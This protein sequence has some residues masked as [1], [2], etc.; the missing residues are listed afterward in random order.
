MRKDPNALENLASLL[1]LGLAVSSA[2]MAAV[3]V[4]AGLW[5]Y[6]GIRHAAST[7]TQGQAI[8]IA[9]SARRA[10]RPAAD[11]N[12]QALQEVLEELAA[13][14]LRYVEVRTADHV[15]VAT[16]GKQ[17]QDIEWSA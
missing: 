8:G 11:I 1:A 14:G 15:L 13:Q 5:V 17:A 7:V 16:A 12:A 2:A 6:A 4:A 9:F 3:L 10:L